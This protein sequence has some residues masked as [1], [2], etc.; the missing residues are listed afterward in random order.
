MYKDV[1]GSTLIGYR[2]ESNK[3]RDL[4]YTHTQMK[5]I[6]LGWDVEQELAKE[7]RREGWIKI[8]NPIGYDECFIINSKHL[9]IED[10]KMDDLDADASKAKIRGAFKKAQGNT[11]KTRKML[12]DLMARVA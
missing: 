8:E 10:N 1:T 5:G 7:Y 4:V 11:K 6:R 9:G 2:I 12:T 3:T